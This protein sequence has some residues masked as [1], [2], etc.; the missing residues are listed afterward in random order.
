MSAGPMTACPLCSRVL[1]HEQLYEHIASERARFRHSTIKVI[2]AYHP[3][4]IEDQGACGRC[5]RSY[6]DA[7]QI[8]NVLKGIRPQN[9]A[10]PWK[11]SLPAT[12][13]YGMDQSPDAY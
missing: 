7:S 10:G 3:G 12:E 13:D 1:P 4:W 11:P 2:Q 8:V 9:A 6:R 5:W